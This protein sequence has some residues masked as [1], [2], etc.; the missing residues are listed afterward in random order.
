MGTTTT[1]DKD[2]IS[3][4]NILLF[5]IIRGLA[6]Q[7][8]YGDS[9]VRIL[10]ESDRSPIVNTFDGYRLHRIYVTAI[11]RHA[12]I[13]VAGGDAAGMRYVYLPVVSR[14]ASPQQGVEPPLGAMPS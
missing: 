3:I 4:F 5:A 8:G 10:I 11:R 2:H 14:A 6:F 7:R 9:P 1:G 13:H 12:S